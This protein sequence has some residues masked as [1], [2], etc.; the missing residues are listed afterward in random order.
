MKKIE[1]ILCA[2]DFSEASSVVAE[3]ALTAARAYG[4]ELLV[5][6]VAPALDRYRDFM[7]SST[8][9]EHFV[10]SVVVGAEQA[11][12]DFVARAFP[13]TPVIT[14]V[15]VGY[16][17]VTIVEVARTNECGMIIMGTYGRRGLDRAL[18][19]SVTERVIKTSPVPV[20]SVRPPR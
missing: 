12:A 18:F 10:A 5:L 7:V 3:H 8:S 13:D 6:Y 20:L 16:P 11:M 9:V 4:A 1:R 14:K 17:P 15:V 19:G 2:V